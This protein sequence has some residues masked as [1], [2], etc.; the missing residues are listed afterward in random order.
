[1]NMYNRRS[2]RLQG[3]DYSQPGLYYLTL[4]T[5]DRLCIFGEIRN[6][7]MV[8]N[9]IGHHA[10]KCWLQIPTHFPNTVLH[11]YI[12]MPNHLHGIV[13]I[14][15]ANHYLPDE[16]RASNLRAKDGSINRAKDV[17][18]LRGTSKTIGSIVRG[19]K[20]GVTRYVRVHTDED[21]IWQRNYYEHIIRDGNDYERIV[22][23]IRSNPMNWQQDDLYL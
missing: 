5:R 14:V 4:S 15:G 19:F 7:E 23:Y 18:P 2:I 20:I 3:Y 1:M 12:I 9:D 10:E 16:N 6:N 8:L 22:N 11:E 13:E 21:K 17:S